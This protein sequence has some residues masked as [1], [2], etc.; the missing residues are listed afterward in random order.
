MPIM[1]SFTKRD[2]IEE[3]GTGTMMQRPILFLTAFAGQQNKIVAHKEMTAKEQMACFVVGCACFAALAVTGACIAGASEMHFRRCED[4]STTA[5][6]CCPANTGGKLD[7]IAK[8]VA[9]MN[10]KISKLQMD[11]SKLNASCDDEKV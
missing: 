9:E 10:V 11:I 7:G 2:K 3:G 8:N 4:R 6:Y 5:T 1:T